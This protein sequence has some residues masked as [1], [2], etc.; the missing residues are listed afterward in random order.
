MERRGIELVEM[1]PNALAAAAE[2]GEIDAAPLPIVDGLHLQDRFEPV[3]GFG[4]ASVQKA[5]S[6]FLYA[7]EPVEA[8]QGA[9]IGVMDGARRR[10][11]F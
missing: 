11:G 7:T 9:R 8:L 3:S 6:V 4:L 10:Y 1:R 2:R 5:G